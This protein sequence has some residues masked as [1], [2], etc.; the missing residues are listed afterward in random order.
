M[1]PEAKADTHMS[2]SQIA[3]K[4]SKMR[5]MAKEVRQKKSVDTVNAKKDPLNETLESV[6]ESTTKKVIAQNFM[7]K[8]GGQGGGK[9]NGS[10]VVSKE[11]KLVEDLNKINELN[12]IMRMGNG[13]S[14]TEHQLY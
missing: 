2:I 11:R 13:Y 3:N 14:D 10:P 8:G 9:S 6:Y 5:D 1:H 7:K 12:S 4:Y